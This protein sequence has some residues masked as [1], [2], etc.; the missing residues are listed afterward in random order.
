MLI[1]LQIQFYSFST[2]IRPGGGG[3][4]SQDTGTTSRVGGQGG[5][6]YVIVWEYK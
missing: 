4:G 3:S 5:D 1:V 2:K 6:G